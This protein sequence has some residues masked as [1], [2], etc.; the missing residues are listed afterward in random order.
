MVPV[1]SIPKNLGQ[2]KLRKSF[3]S[4]I[5][6]EEKVQKRKQ[7]AAH[8]RFTL[9]IFWFGHNFGLLPQTLRFSSET[10]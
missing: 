10:L 6:I 2:V 1:S 9:I 7:L 4:D 3:S 8:A 5:F